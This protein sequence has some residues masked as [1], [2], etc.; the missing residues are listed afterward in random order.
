[1]F[2]SGTGKLAYTDLIIL[3]SLLDMIPI[4]N[5]EAMAARDLYEKDAQASKIDRHG[6]SG[7]LKI[8]LW[9]NEKSDCTLLQQLEKY[10]CV[11]EKIFNIEEKHQ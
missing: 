1:M 3:E 4:D 11:L 6:T 2:V 5:V 8:L 10:P 9:R 7:G